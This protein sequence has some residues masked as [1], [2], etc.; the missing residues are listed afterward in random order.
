M[1]LLNNT[2]DK[3]EIKIE[4]LKIFFTLFKASLVNI[5]AANNGISAFVKC[6]DDDEL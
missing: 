5:N 2:T 3:I 4:F 1:N 6:E